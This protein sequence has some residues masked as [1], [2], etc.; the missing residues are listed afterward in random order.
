MGILTGKTAIL[1]FFI[2]Y[3]CFNYNNSHLNDR[4]FLMLIIDKERE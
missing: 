1:R 2:T 4:V 3:D